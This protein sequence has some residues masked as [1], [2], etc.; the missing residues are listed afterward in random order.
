MG[1]A[2]LKC[3]ALGCDHVGEVPA[4]TRELIGTPC[5][6]CGANLLTEADADQWLAQVEPLLA[7]LKPLGLITDGAFDVPA[8]QRVEFHL[9]EAKLTI[10]TQLPSDVS[11]VEQGQP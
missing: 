4:I 7:F 5:P 10:S 9:H 6:K 2:F 8:D 11:I 3:D 1:S